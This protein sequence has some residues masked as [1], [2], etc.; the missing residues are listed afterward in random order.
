MAALEGFC[1]RKRINPV[2]HRPGEKHRHIER[3][4]QG[5]AIGLVGKSSPCFRKYWCGLVSTL[6]DALALIKGGRGGQQGL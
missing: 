4:R 2:L 5:A 1:C 3:N 6:N